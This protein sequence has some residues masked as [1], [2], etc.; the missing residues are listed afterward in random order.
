MEP[1]RQLDVQNAFV[2]GVLEEERAGMNRCKAVSTPLSA[3]EKLSLRDGEKLGPEDSTRYRSIILFKGAHWLRL[4]AKLQQSEERTH[5]IV[6]GCR[7]M[8]TP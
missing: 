6:E 3:T 2:H 1:T 4:W 5:M 8:E 7:R